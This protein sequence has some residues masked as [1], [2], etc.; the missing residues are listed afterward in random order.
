VNRVL[1]VRVIMFATTL[2]LFAAKAAGS[3]FSDG[4]R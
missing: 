1:K 4:F 3:G 2:A